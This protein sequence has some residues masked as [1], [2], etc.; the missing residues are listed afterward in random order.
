M[1]FMDFFSRTKVEIQNKKTTSYTN[2][3]LLCVTL[4]IIIQF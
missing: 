4:I 2:W 3:C 1:I